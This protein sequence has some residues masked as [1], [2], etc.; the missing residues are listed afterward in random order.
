LNWSEA[1]RRARR[2]FQ[3][4]LDSAVLPYEMN[5]S[6]LFSAE[7][8]AFMAK[9]VERLLYEPQLPNGADAERRIVKRLKET[10]RP[11]PSRIS[12]WNACFCSAK[13]TA[14]WIAWSG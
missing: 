1:D 12:N 3:R 10:A 4:V 13:R 2:E 11:N 7:E 8:E 6:G 5:Q 14:R 9:E